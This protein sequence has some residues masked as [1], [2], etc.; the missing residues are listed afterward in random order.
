MQWDWDPAKDRENL[1]KHGISFADAL[2]AF[3]DTKN[4]T[5]EDPYRYEQ[6]WRTIGTVGPAIIMVVHTWE[7]TGGG[8]F[9]GRIISARKANSHE[10][11]QYE[12]G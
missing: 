9:R 5:V 6:R 8:G 11:A 2:Q 1:R 3:E 10:R 4:L 7:Q 12:E